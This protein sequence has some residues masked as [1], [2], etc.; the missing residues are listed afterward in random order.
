M[1]S[2]S[3]ALPWS[4]ILLVAAAAVPADGVWRA[5]LPRWTN[6]FSV[7]LTRMESK[8][9]VLVR[10]KFRVLGP[11][12]APSCRLLPSF[13]VFSRAPLSKNSNSCTSKKKSKV[14]V[15]KSFE[16]RDTLIQRVFDGSEVGVAPMRTPVLFGANTGLTVGTNALERFLHE[17]QIM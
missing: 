7:D 6:V 17:R 8:F 16:T 10:K 13:A 14:C 15:V 9:R 1:V 5:C 4:Q 11:V 2:T 12:G 3:A